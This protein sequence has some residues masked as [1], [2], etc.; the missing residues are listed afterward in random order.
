MYHSMRVALTGELMT[1]INRDFGSFA[2]LKEQMTA[3]TVAVQGSGWGW[4]GYNKKAGR[5]QVAACANQD[6]LQATTGENKQIADG[7]VYVLSFTIELCDYLH[8]YVISIVFAMH[9]KPK[10]KVWL[11]EVIVRD[12]KELLCL[13]VS[14]N[15]CWLLFQV[16][17][18]C[19]VLTCGSMPTICNTRTCVPI[20]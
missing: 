7:V 11:I 6:P 15:T 18:R 5:L 17:C 1:A 8:V 10:S 3:A 12:S 4:L 16:W 2:N 19:L 9:V 14:L 20:T 13:N